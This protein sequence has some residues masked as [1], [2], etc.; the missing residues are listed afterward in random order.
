M[1]DKKWPTGIKLSRDGAAPTEVP[2]KVAL[3][4]G[5]AP[6]LKVDLKKIFPL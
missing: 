2:L 6:G 5:P 4:P 3:G 1:R